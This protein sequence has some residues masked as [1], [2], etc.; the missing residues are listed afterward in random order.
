MFNAFQVSKKKKKEFNKWASQSS[1]F[2]CSF[3]LFKA[4]KENKP[5]SGS[6]MMLIPSVFILTWQCQ[7]LLSIQCLLSGPWVISMCQWRIVM[8]N[9]AALFSFFLL[10]K[11]LSYIYKA[12]CSFIYLHVVTMVVFKRHINVW[13]PEVPFMVNTPLSIFFFFFP[14]GF[15]LH[16]GSRRNKNF[17]GKRC[18]RGVSEAHLHSYPQFSS[19]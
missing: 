1:D 19:A 7:S 6:Y 2:Y 11:I 9:S 8:L 12:M 16:H 15:L 17:Q 4:I 3:L 5:P 10:R 18:S 13:K 14:S